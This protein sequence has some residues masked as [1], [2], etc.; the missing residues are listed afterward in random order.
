M[1]K[2]ATRSAVGRPRDENAER[3]IL[4]TTYDHLIQYGYSRMSIEGIAAAAGVG[5]TTIYRRFANKQ[6]LAAA[7]I[8]HAEPVEQLTETNNTRAAL[9][10]I[11]SLLTVAMFEHGAVRVIGSLLA[12]EINDP[13]LL[14]TFRERVIGPRRKIIRGILEH[15]IA[16][17]QIRTDTDIDITIDMFLG[18]VIGR[19]L[20]GV[21]DDP[22]WADNVMASLWR[23]IGT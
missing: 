14:A 1:S 19:Y 10:E 22:A 5:K 21:P 15:G 2:V 16:T 20:A 23:M 9:T 17:G 18:S 11:F 13:G 4:T 3:A 6:E 12:E 8:I 7:A